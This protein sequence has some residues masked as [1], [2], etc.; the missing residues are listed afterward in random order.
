MTP[1]PHPAPPSSPGSAVLSFVSGLDDAWPPSDRCDT[2]RLFPSLRLGT[3]PAVRSSVADM[4][5]FDGMVLCI[6][7]L[8]ASLAPEEL[9]MVV[10]DACSPPLALI[11]PGH[12]ARRTPPSGGIPF[13]TAF[14]IGVLGPL[15]R[16]LGSPGPSSAPSAPD[17]PPDGSPLRIDTRRTPCLTLEWTPCAPLPV[18]AC[19][20]DGS[21][22]SPRRSAP[23][24]PLGTA[25]GWADAL[26]PL[27]APCPAPSPLEMH[28]AADALM[29]ALADASAAGMVAGLRVAARPLAPGEDPARR[30]RWLAARPDGTVAAAVA[31]AP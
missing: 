10:P 2:A 31:L 20:A 16:S 29:D 6:L 19:R 17:I 18:P 9:R 30:V 27:I 8:T 7:S 13:V 3:A 21:P 22:A 26:G 25:L 28:A 12:A 4:T 23:L 15:L 14:G 5:S 11:A 24:P 1:S